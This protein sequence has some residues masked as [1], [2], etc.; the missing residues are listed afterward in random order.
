MAD[1]LKRLQ[2]NKTLY[3][4]LL[5]SFATDYNAVANEI[6]E[7]LDAEDFDQAHS[8]LHNFKGLA[9]NIAASE[10]RA[11]A[12]NLE[13]LVKGIDRKSASP[14]QLD[15]ILSDLENVLNQVLESAQ[16]LEA[17]ADIPAEL[18]QDIAE[19]IGAAAE[20]GDLM[21]LNAIAEEIKDQSESNMLLS[22]QIVQ[23]AEDLDLDGI[24][25]L[26]DK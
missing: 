2:G 1:G 17:S 10:L 5:L 18:S 7:A 6:R 4:K 9:G 12:V 19:R 22:K 25:K 8:L 20:M 21:T 26:T 14:K 16:S 13:T 11:V 24:Q 23:M 15:L 3:R